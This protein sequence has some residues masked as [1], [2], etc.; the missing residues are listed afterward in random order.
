[1]EPIATEFISQSIF[2]M[3][4]NTPRIKKCLFQL[5]DAEVWIRPNQSIN[6][7]A[8]LVLHLCGNITQYI[9]SSLGGK[10]DTRIRDKEFSTTN[11]F[12]C[13]QLIDKITITVND[14]ITTIRSIDETELL[15]SRQV[16]GFNLTGIGIIIHVVEHYSYHTGQIAL[17]TKLIKDNDLAFYAGVDLNKKNE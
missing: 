8:N 14:A 4:E 7:I 16:Q 2:R 3:E 17:F 9:I 13:N 11:G 1:M 5:T 15:R 10:P 6:S 12:T